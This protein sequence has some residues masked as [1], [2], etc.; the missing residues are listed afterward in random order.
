MRD[1]RREAIAYLTPP[2]GGFWTWDEGGAVAVMRGGGT[3]AF[4][5]ELAV[6][7]RRLAP[8][9]VPPL[10]AVL[11]LFAALRDS[12]LIE[13][14]SVEVFDDESSQGLDAQIR[15]GLERMSRIDAPLRS[16]LRAK[17]VIAEMIFEGGEY[18]VDPELAGV[19]VEL[20]EAGL[21]DSVRDGY[22]DVGENASV[23]HW[24]HPEQ[25]A[26]LAPGLKRFDAGELALRLQTG[27][28]ALPGAADVDLPAADRVRALLVELQDDDELA[29]L[30]GLARN[31]MAAV[32]LP[33]PIGEA[34]EMP[35]GGVSDI[36]N[37]GPLDRLLLSELAH[38]DLTLAV[39]VAVG[40]AL[41]LR[42]ETPPRTPPRRRTMLLDVGLRTWGVPRVFAAA[43]ALA[44]AATADRHVELA[45]YRARGDA[46][47][48]VDLTT[49][50]GLLEHLA[51][52]AVELHPGEAF[53]A[54]LAQL[55]PDA[56]EP[57]LV[58]TDEVLDDAEFHTRL[59][60]ASTPMLIAAVSRQ[61][62][63]NLYEDSPRGRKLLRQVQLDLDALSRRSPT[64]P[65]LASVSLLDESQSRELPAILS[66]SPFPLLLPQQFDRNRTWSV[67]GHGVFAVSKD[68]RL[69]QFLHSAHGGRQ[70]SDVLP[71]ANVHW[72]E[73]IEY[74][75]RSYAVVGAKQ[76]GRLHLL[77]LL[78][79]D[80]SCE[81]SRL[82]IDSQPVK[83]VCS[84]LGALFVVQGRRVEVLEMATG[85]RLQTIEVSR[86]VK[87]LRGRLFVNLRRRN[88]FA[89]SLDNATTT[90]FEP[91][92]GAR[93][94]HCPKLLTMF[95]R[96]G[97][98]GPIGVTTRGDLYF[99]ATDELRQTQ[100]D[101][102]G[103]V[104][105]L[106]VSHDGRRLALGPAGEKRRRT[107]TIV[108]VDTG[109][110]RRP[111]SPYDSSVD[112]VFE[113]ELHRTVSHRSL[114][115]RL[116]SAFIDGV[117]GL[118]TFRA[119]GHLVSLAYDSQKQT[120][121]FTEKHPWQAVQPVAETHR[122]FLFLDCP[123][124]RGAGYLLRVAQ[125]NGGK[126]VI[127]SRGLLHLIS[128]DPR[129]PQAT[130]VLNDAQVSVW[131]N[132][133][134]SCGEDYFLLEAATSNP[135]EI[136]QTVLEPFVEGLR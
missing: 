135:R 118:L 7:L 6:V 54:Y 98:D 91:V 1:L 106:G 134:R 10:N 44:V 13:Q 92:L 56:S 35:L 58:T 94:V 74:D 11:L 127:D 80:K 71:S 119:R 136:Y 59:R 41:Y 60:E 129:L 47:D 12:G 103:P 131:C 29:A 75:G 96:R 85:R 49:R 105:V 52:L 104:G 123:G 64:R 121:Y 77:D 36:S 90:G 48:P 34:D 46:V 126:A 110:S 28:D 53:T 97:I 66:V 125:W 22:V 23:A 37:R 43:V 102:A 76:S 83:C 16:P 21:G 45:V 100:H 3:I 50:A 20:L 18:D 72:F 24:F 63:L 86:G 122:E 25:L 128:S 8:Q 132:D 88:Y 113:P 111:S 101:V 108:D 57:L 39:R 15:A 5:A 130:L 27:L 17:A 14:V 68:R 99:T 114:R 79:D 31:L 26:C 73:G 93:S 62:D 95:E 30:A 2:M 42:R 61:G 38:D 107:A 51:A 32:A 55:P 82:E 33:R 133:G 78:L 87:H 84:H 120:I 40:E 65:K 116:S 117:D 109:E 89:L 19:A 67:E 9:G 112:L 70:W 124:K 69:L 81:I 4:T 115:H